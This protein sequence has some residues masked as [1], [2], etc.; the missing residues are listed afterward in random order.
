MFSSFLSLLG[1]ADG[2][3]VPAIIVAVQWQDAHRPHQKTL[4][5]D[6]PKK[7]KGIYQ[8][9]GKGARLV[10]GKRWKVLGLC[11]RALPWEGYIQIL[12][13]NGDR[14]GCYRATTGDVETGTIV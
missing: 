14:I 9:I 8:D 3:L 13:L 6:S 7:F 12:T 11:L 10:W 4:G 2:P 1:M 5:S